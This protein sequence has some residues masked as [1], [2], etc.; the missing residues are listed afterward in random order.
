MQ[1]GR[2]KTRKLIQ[3][4]SQA[5][6]KIEAICHW[7]STLPLHGAKNTTCKWND[8]ERGIQSKRCE[9]QLIA[10]NGVKRFKSERTIL[11]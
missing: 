4:S 1:N 3:L 2:W 9:E 8:S 5:T 6:Q 10:T 11:K 7:K